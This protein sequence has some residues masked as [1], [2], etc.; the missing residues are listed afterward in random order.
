MNS[1]EKNARQYLSQAAENRSHFR[2]KRPVAACSMAALALLGFMEPAVAQTV[3][4]DHV[5]VGP[6]EARPAGCDVIGDLDG[7]GRQE[8]ITGIATRALATIRSGASG[9]Q[10]HGH[11][12]PH[13]SGA[14]TGFGGAVA[15]IGDFDGDLI[16]DYAVGSPSYSD[17]SIGN[18][19]GMVFVY[20]GSSHNVIAR[21]PG[22]IPG[23]VSG[24]QVVGLGDVNGDG[25]SDVGIAP[26]HGFM[27]RIHLGPDG[28]LLRQTAGGSGVPENKGSFGDHDGDGCADYLVGNR[29]DSTL[30]NNA[31]GV[32][33]YSGKTGLPLLVMHAD[34]PDQL[35]GHSVS[36]GGDWNGD[37]IEDI[38]AGAP[39][40]TQLQNT[41]Y[42]AGVYVFSG[43]DG[44]ILHYFD[45][46]AYC[47][48]KSAFGYSVSSGKDVN[49]D[50]VPDLI[51]GAPLHEW[52]PT[53]HPTYWMGESFVFSGATKELLWRR[54][55]TVAG[56]RSGTRVKLI[57]D[58]NSDGLADWMVMGPL[59]DDGTGPFPYEQGRVTIFA[60]AIGDA[61]SHCTGGPNSLGLE[62][63]LRGTGPISLGENQFALQLTDMPQAKAAL[64]V[65]QRSLAPATPFGAG[66]LCLQTPLGY[67]GFVTTST[68]SSPTDPGQAS[69]AIDLTVGPFGSSSNRLQPGESWAFQ[70]LY[71]DQGQR[72]TSN[73]LEVVFVP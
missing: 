57:D 27:F 66:E 64:I 7:D 4:W 41:N 20:S 59:Y 65:H 9:A 32:R 6:R 3:V 39:G 18:S 51:V 5:G 63:Q 34:R 60:G 13:H 52:T 30:A 44:S 19:T 43:A 50:G 17:L 48:Q 70:A 42:L 28:A 47:Q 45:G 8:V 10:L 53:N 49:G 67:L 2:R 56:E 37:G 11:Y 62:A 68:E 12:L 54:R 40:L 25:Y 23:E 24:Q 29:L 71:R 33:L 73:A 58:H 55:G 21:I 14:T 61:V 35:A 36:R 15:G 1:T 38:I 69:L 16:P 72:N 26:L 22:L 46:E 31:G